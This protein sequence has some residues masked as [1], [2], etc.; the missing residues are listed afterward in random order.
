[1]ARPNSVIIVDEAGEARTLK[2][3]RLVK[4]ERPAKEVGSKD[5]WKRYEAGGKVILNFEVVK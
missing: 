5:G 3:L 1:M 4:G 2:S